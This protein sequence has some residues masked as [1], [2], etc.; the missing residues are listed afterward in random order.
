MLRLDQSALGEL[1]AQSRGAQ[2][3]AF[4]EDRIA[5]VFRPTV[6]PSVPLREFELT[7]A[8]HAAG[9][10]AWRV[11]ELVSIDGRTAIIGERIRGVTLAALLRRS[12]RQLPGVVRALV[13]VQEQISR[14]DGVDPAV[15]SHSRGT[16]PSFDAAQYGPHHLSRVAVCHGDLHISNVMLTEDGRIVVIDWSNAFYGPLVADVANSHKRLRRR[17]LAHERRPAAWIAKRVALA[18]H[19]RL[20]CRKMGLS[21][22]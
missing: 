17:L 1:V 9:A 16:P 5:K 20:A 11:D 15:W 12:I 7:R 21:R 19:R 14:L 2:V 10:P 13:R 8:V 4:G 18:A 22:F 6:R 3:F